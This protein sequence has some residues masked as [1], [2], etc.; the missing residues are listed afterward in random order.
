[1][2]PF[3]VCSAKT[4]RA[5]LRHCVQFPCAQRFDVNG[6]SCSVSLCGRT[7][8]SAVLQ[9]DTSV[10]FIGIRARVLGPFVCPVLLI[11]LYTCTHRCVDTQRQPYGNMKSRLL[12]TLCAHISWK[13]SLCFAC[14][15]AQQSRA[16]R[17]VSRTHTMQPFAE[18]I[19]IGHFGFG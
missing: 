2:H 6:N 10:V 3:A 1:M 14:L 16:Y 9:F 13:H 19:S 8:I 18:R 5:H 11:R 7:A 15:V 12:F 17:I 4:Y